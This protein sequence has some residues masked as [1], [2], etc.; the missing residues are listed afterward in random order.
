MLVVVIY[1]KFLKYKLLHTSIMIQKCFNET[2]KKPVLSL[3]IY[4]NPL[5]LGPKIFITL[6]DFNR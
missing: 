5:T 3:P 2:K 6:I 4:K 1:I